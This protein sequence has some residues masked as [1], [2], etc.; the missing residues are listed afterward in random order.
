[1]AVGLPVLTAAPVGTGGSS[2]CDVDHFIG[3]SRAS[4][5]ACARLTT[6]TNYNFIAINDQLQYVEPDIILI[7]IMKVRK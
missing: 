3:D 6:G 5:P 1:M 7:A 4:S 2:W